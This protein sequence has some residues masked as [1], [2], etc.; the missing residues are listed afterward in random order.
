MSRRH[1]MIACGCLT[2]LASLGLPQ[3]GGRAG[4]ANLRHGQ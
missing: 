2:M 4:G 3:F 1:V